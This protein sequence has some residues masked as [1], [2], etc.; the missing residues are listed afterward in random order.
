MATN[1]LLAEI[2]GLSPAAKSA[3]IQAHQSA[4]NPTGVSNPPDGGAVR[5]ISPITDP[6]SQPQVPPI[7]VNPDPQGS[8][9]PG[10]S[11]PPMPMLPP[12]AAP[13]VHG[14]SQ[15]DIDQQEL[16]RKVNTGSGI[17]Q[18]HSKIENSG[19]GQAHPL[20]GKALGWGAQIPA[21]LADVATSAVAP[22]IT[23]NLPG[24]EYHHERLVKQDQRQVAGDVANDEKQ[25]QTANLEAQPELQQAKSDLANQ[26]LTETTTHH[27]AQV[28]QQLRAHGFKT[29]PETGSI[30]P[31]SY[32]EMSEPQQA[33]YDL[34]NSQGALADANAELAKA[35]NDPNSPLYKEATD[36]IASIHRTQDIALQRLGLSREQ[37]MMR[38]HGTDLE[39][40]ALNGAMLGD[41]NE[42]IGT[43]LQQNVR[44]TGQERNKADLAN[45]ASSQI[46]DMKSIVQKHPEFFG[47]GYGQSTAF[48][49]WVGSG[50]PD[51]KRFVAARTIA[52][53][54]L[55]GT[56]GGRSEY[57]LKALDDAL[58]QFKENPKAAMAGLDQLAGANKIFQK[59]GTVKTAGSN[60]A[61]P[62]ETQTFQAN[63]KT[64]TIPADKVAAFK[65]DFPN[66]K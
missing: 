32:G 20:L 58:G 49:N 36:K 46:N 59:A 41:N 27:Q 3:L 29:N 6:H 10:G 52:A 17:S 21:T 39:G 33:A 19:F 48:K 37:F 47:P 7:G 22:A 51:A 45:S 23:A 38:A 24:T 35:K 31:L 53:D 14:P 55:A 13:S 43:A 66:A 44:P 56:F 9:R 50:D 26:K 40:N 16:A 62:S 64:Y 61:A 4:S 60:A 28:D 18:I 11:N 63:G 25:A 8:L 12:G 57:A 42:P 34:K 2:N 65:K 54:H 15:T 1:P 5:S 30:E